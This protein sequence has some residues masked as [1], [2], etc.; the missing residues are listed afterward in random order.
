LVVEVFFRFEELGGSED[1]DWAMV[2]G[3]HCYWPYSEHNAGARST[4][5]QGNCFAQSFTGSVMTATGYNRSLAG[6]DSTAGI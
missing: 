1:I 5:R 2:I 6:F 4:Q 3:D